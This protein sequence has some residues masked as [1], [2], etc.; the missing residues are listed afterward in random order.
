[1]NPHTQ[2]TNEEC[3][4][5]ENDPLVSMAKRLFG[6]QDSETFTLYTHG[7]RQFSVKEAR[8]WLHSTSIADVQ[9]Y[10]QASHVP[11][12]IPSGVQLLVMALA[13]IASIIL[14]A[15]FVDE[16]THDEQIIA[17]AEGTL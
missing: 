5:S 3:W 10:R 17:A 4:L 14:C 9:Q 16:P 11:G 12:S 7:D 15:C 6:K 8:I 2:L 1:M 13:V